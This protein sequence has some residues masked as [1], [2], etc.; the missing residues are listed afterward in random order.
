MSL[1]I[2]IN[3]LN[4]RKKINKTAVRKA[5]LTVIRGFKKKNVAVDITFVTDKQIMQLNKRYMRRNKPTDVLSFSMIEKTFPGQTIFGDIYISSDTV[6]A[7]AL[8]FGNSF[9]GEIVLCV[10]HGMLHMFGFKDKT[11]KEKKM[12]RGLEENFLR[13]Y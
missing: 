9:V 5:A 3:S 8:R 6:A 4:N 12:M 7:N 13:K 11:P 1:R 10:I 2:K